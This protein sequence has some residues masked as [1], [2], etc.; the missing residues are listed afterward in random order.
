[1]KLIFKQRFFSWL[2]SYDIYD[3]HG[4]IAYTVEGKMSW[5]HKLHVLDRSGRH[6][7]TLRERV[8]TFLPQFEIYIGEQYMGC[9]R[10]EL[11]LLRPR[12]TV[13]CNDWD[14]EGNFW[15][16]DYRIVCRTGAV[17]A[18]VSKELLRLTDTYVIDVENPQNSLLAL[19]V[20]LALDAEKCSRN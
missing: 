9:I 6:I 19:L 10:K 12:F 5:G 18:N 4:E 15:E 17:V 8:L 16:W 13:E 20:V 11:S 1:M 3:E 7:A 14:V 2:D